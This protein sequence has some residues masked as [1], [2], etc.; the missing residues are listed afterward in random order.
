MLQRLM[1]PK[2]LCPH[3]LA[4]TTNV[5]SFHVWSL[6]SSGMTH[7][8]SWWVVRRAQIQTFT[9]FVALTLKIMVL[10]PRGEIL[11]RA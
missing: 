11:E 9:F 3:G 2:T 4:K 10:G 8:R 6:F 1:I 5:L 7:T